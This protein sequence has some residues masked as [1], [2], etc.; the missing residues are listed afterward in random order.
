M[1]NV[2]TKA[3]M[4]KI[5]RKN[6]LWIMTDQHQ[7]G[8]LGCMG[9]P[10]IQT[11]N[12]DRLAAEGTLFENAFCQSPVC[13]A[14]RGSVLTGRYPASIRIRGMGVLPPSETTLP[15][16]LRRQGYHTG[17]FGKVHLTP[18]QYTQ[19]VLKSDVPILDWQHFAKDACLAAF[20]DDPYKTNYGF[21]TH[22]GCDDACR[23]NHVAWIQREA[24]ELLTRRV[25]RIP[26]APGDLYV[27]PFPSEYHASTYIAK[28]ADSYIRS[29]AKS[30]TPWM[31]FCSFIA[32]HHPFEAPADQIERYN[33]ADIPLPDP[34]VGVDIQT[35]PDALRPA[36]N[37]M[38]QYSESVQRQIVRHYYASISLI[39]D[40]VGRLITAV[41]ETGQRDN[42]VV[43]FVSD[44]GE[45]LGQHGLLRK[46]SFHYD[47]VLRVPLI[48]NWPGNKSGRRI[49]G[50]VE[51]TD[52]YPTLLGLLDLPVNPGVQGRNW[53][54]ELRTND[55]IGRDDCYSDMYELDPMTHAKGS[56]PY[57]ACQTI[58]TEDYKLNVYPTAGQE[59]SQLFDLKNDPRETSNRFHDPAFQSIRENMLW[60]MTARVHANT[61]PLPLRLTQW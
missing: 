60:R 28:Q 48:L 22:V 49:G 18:E 10:V 47:E 3:T 20:P 33:D 37:E 15:E 40:C 23:G 14:S 2:I 46:P 38:L 61:D 24:P 1:R 39:D 9:N 58:R 6:L 57:C 27:S 55:R 42:T 12:L 52:L 7:A 31:T 17:A 50:L 13:M 56:G 53:S 35:P 8:C 21:E 19:K 36:I 25:S 30:D 26:D 59:S 41:E 44:H 5:N 34:E 32:P 4:T 29:N 11:P 16:W 45:H 54:G 51:L 43:V